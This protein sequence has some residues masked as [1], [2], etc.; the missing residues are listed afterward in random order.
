MVNILIQ[1]ILKGKILN[2]SNIEKGFFKFDKYEDD[3]ALINYE[4]KGQNYLDD[5]SYFVNKL[6]D[7]EEL[8]L[9]GNVDTIEIILIFSYQ[10]QGNIEIP[11]EIFSKIVK[12]NAHLSL[13]FYENFDK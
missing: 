11:R 2:L 5:L 1:A 9:A 6:Y 8:L 12:M 3:Y 13:S 10:K 7:Y 4:G